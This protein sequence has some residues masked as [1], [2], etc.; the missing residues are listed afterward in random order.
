MVETMHVWGWGVYGQS[1][2]LPVNFAMK[3][4]LLLKHT[5]SHT[6][7][8]PEVTHFKKGEGIEILGRKQGLKEY[9]PLSE[10]NMNQKKAPY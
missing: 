7:T 3:L 6:H 9:I 2:Y 1:L 10:K 4:K 5:H 8:C